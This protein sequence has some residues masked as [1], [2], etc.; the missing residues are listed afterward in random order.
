MR[1]DYW[2]EKSGEEGEQKFIE[3]SLV[4]SD[5]VQTEDDWICAMVSKGVNSIAYRK[6]LGRYAPKME[7]PLYQFHQTYFEHMNR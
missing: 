1:F 3:D 4:A 7:T 5:V 2:F 6:H